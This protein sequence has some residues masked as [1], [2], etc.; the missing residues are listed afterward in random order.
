MM[1][2]WRNHL[3]RLCQRNF[4]FRRDNPAIIDN[5]IDALKYLKNLSNLTAE[6]SIYP[7]KALYLFGLEYHRKGNKSPDEVRIVQESL[8]KISELVV[9]MPEETYIDL[10][11]TLRFIDSTDHTIWTSVQ[12]RF[13]TTMNHNYPPSFYIHVTIGF[14]STGIKNL[15]M[16]EVIEKELITKVFPNSKLTSVTATIMLEAMANADR[17]TEEIYLKLRNIIIKEIQFLS[18]ENLRK[19]A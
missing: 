1:I 12:Q 5:D 2:Q 11:N 4:A 19:L 16:W 7:I 8:A 18:L 9:H 10:I 17:F 15:E 13:L 3:L 14:G 6:D